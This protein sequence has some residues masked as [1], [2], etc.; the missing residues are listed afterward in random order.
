MSFFGPAEDV[1]KN[2]GKR[3]EDVERQN[4]KTPRRRGATGL[5]LELRFLHTETPPHQRVTLLNQE[6]APKAL[7]LRLRDSAPLR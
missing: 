7:T 3:V 4:A 2:C 5:E 6:R 1:R